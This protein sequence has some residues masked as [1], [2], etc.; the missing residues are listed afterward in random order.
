MIWTYWKVRCCF[1]MINRSENLMLRQRFRLW[2][3]WKILL[4]D[5]FLAPKR[6]LKQDEQKKND[7]KTLQKLRGLKPKQFGR[8]FWSQTNDEKNKFRENDTSRRRNKFRFDDDP[9]DD[10]TTSTAVGRWNFPIGGSFRP[11]VVAKRARKSLGG[12]GRM[13]KT[14]EGQSRRFFGPQK[15]SNFSGIGTGTVNELMLH[16]WC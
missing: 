11:M 1:C 8:W 15:I 14:A 2:I 5:I 10:V 6:H 7:I 3:Y 13:W 4:C 12:P 16:G 9:H